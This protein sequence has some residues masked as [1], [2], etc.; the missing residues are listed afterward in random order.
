MMALLSGEVDVALVTR[1]VGAAHL[2]SNKLRP[3]AAWGAQKWADYPNVPTIKQEGFD[4]DYQLWSGLFAPAATPPDVINVL[5][6]AVGIAAKDEKFK[7]TMAQQGV[8]I[9]YM[10][11][12]EFKQYWDKDAARLIEAVQKIGISQ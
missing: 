2:Q 11:A 5:R 4:V 12:P 3:L 8:A 6:K 10:D 1:S 9:A 7:S